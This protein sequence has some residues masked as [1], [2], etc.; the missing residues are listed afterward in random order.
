MNKEAWYIYTVEYYSAIKRNTSESV[1]MRKMNLKPIIQNEVS[2][3][4][5]K[6]SYI[7]A[8]VWNLERWYS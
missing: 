4:V 7:S 1:L 5:K 2:Q 8:Y 6:K 3:K